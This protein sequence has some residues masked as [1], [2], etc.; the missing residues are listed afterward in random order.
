MMPMAA[1]WKSS[2]FFAAANL[3]LMC[4]VNVSLWSKVIP[5]YLTMFLYSIG[6]LSICSLGKCFSGWEYFL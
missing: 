4:W 5:R 3:S 1:L 6:V 2:D